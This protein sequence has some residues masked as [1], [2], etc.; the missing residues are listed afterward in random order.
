MERI[1]C[2]NW[3][4]GISYQGCQIHHCFVM[5]LKYSESWVSPVSV[6]ENLWP[7]ICSLDIFCGSQ[8]ICKERQNDFFQLPASSS[9][10]PPPTSMTWQQKF[11]SLQPCPLQEAVRLAGPLWRLLLSF[12]NSMCAGAA[13]WGLLF[14]K[15]TIC[16]TPCSILQFLGSWYLLRTHIG[17]FITEGSNREVLIENNGSCLSKWDTACL[18]TIIVT[19][20]SVIFYLL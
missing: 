12:P 3:R 8:E 5:I 11:I 9:F 2:K 14:Q 7:Q 18:Y 10:L 17:N 20:N 19:M 1:L 13:V 15:S 4:T 6:A 16:R